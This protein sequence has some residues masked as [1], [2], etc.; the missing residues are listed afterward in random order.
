M[1]ALCVYGSHNLPCDFPTLSTEKPLPPDFRPSQQLQGQTPFL[2]SCIFR[3]E[4]FPFFL[5]N[6]TSIVARFIYANWGNTRGGRLSLEKQDLLF[7]GAVLLAHP[8]WLSPSGEN[9]ITPIGPSRQFPTSSFL[10][11]PVF[12]ACVAPQ[13]PISS[14]NSTSL[15]ALPSLTVR[16][17][18]GYKCP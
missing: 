12:T 5:N 16:S 1:S 18:Q 15:L 14:N 17:H 6:R 3:G 9:H 13:A 2:C 4:A 11:F 10:F 7:A 8:Y